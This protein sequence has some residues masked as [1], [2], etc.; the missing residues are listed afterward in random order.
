MEGWKSDT[1][2]SFINLLP[3]IPILYQFVASL[4]PFIAGLLLL[5]LLF[6]QKTFGHRKKYSVQLH[7]S[8]SSKPKLGV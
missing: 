4:E 8:S 5:L 3:V 6:L 7:L 1:D 2:V